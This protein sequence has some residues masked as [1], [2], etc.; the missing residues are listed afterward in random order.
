MCAK[1]TPFASLADFD[2]LLQF[3]ALV[4]AYMALTTL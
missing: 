2:K 4:L 3:K 1:I